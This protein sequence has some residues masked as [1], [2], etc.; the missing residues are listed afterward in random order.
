MIPLYSEGT[1]ELNYYPFIHSG[2]FYEKRDKQGAYCGKME[3]NAN[4]PEKKNPKNVIDGREMFQV[5]NGTEFEIWTKLSDEEKKIY[6]VI[7]DQSIRVCPIIGE[8]TVNIIKYD[9]VTTDKYAVIKLP[10]GGRD[11]LVGCDSQKGWEYWK[12]RL[13]NFLPTLIY[14]T[15]QSIRL[16]PNRYFECSLDSNENLLITTFKDCSL[17]DI[18]TAMTSNSKFMIK[19]ISQSID[20]YYDEVYYPKLSID[21]LLKK[22]KMDD[23]TFGD[24]STQP[25]TLYSILDQ[26]KL[27]SGFKEYDNDVF[28]R[29]LASEDTDSNGSDEEWDL[30]ESK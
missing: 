16:E 29:Y 11:Y 5:N 9:E 6:S 20:Q 2:K 18:D 23:I 27:S 24:Q 28:D 15:N 19:L 4:H 7:T 17:S 14:L 1:R 8:M 30:S 22:I 3:I 13:I 21:D 12:S 25:S 10:Q 26:L